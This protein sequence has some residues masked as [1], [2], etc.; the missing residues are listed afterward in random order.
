MGEKEEVLTHDTIGRVGDVKEAKGRRRSSAVGLCERTLVRAFFLPRRKDFLFLRPSHGRI[1]GGDLRRPLVRWTPARKVHGGR[2]TGQKPPAI[3]PGGPPASGGIWNSN[4]ADLNFL[5]PRPNLS[6]SSSQGK[7][8]ATTETQRLLDDDAVSFLWTLGK[9]ISGRT[10]K[11]IPER[12]LLR[13]RSADS[14][15]FA[16]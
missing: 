7:A 4:V 12:G 10:G 16:L 8:A 14:D 3:P 13:G 5:T 1:V 2:L 9:T 6:S 15:S 11:G